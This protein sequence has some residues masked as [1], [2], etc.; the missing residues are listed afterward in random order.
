MGTEKNS[1]FMI[2]VAILIQRVSATGVDVSVSC[3]IVYDCSVVGK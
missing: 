3:F 1:K 2:F